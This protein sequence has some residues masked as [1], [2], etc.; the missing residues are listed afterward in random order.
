MCHNRQGDKFIHEH[1]FKSRTVDICIVMELAINDL[2]ISNYQ[3]EELV[4]IRLLP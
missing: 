1:A 4:M 2:E 3:A